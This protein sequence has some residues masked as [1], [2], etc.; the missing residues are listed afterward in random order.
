MHRRHLRAVMERFATQTMTKVA[1]EIRSL[2]DCKE[3]AV[4]S[5]PLFYGQFYIGNI[6]LKINS[7]LLQFKTHFDIISY[8]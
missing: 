1:G 2:I 4:D 5:I 8:D 6:K 3:M 7:F